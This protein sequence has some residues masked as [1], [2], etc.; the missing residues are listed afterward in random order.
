MENQKVNFKYEMLYKHLNELNLTNAVQNFTL[1]NNTDIIK[2]IEY[3]K[4]RTL[5]SSG[6]KKKLYEDAIEN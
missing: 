6:G 3:F 2:S 5:N 1:S 4:A